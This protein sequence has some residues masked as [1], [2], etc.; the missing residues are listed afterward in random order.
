MKIDIQ[1]QG[2][3]C[4]FEKF[5]GYLGFRLESYDFKVSQAPEHKPP[6]L[7]TLNKSPS[8]AN[9]QV[10]ENKTP[11]YVYLGCLESCTCK[12]SEWKTGDTFFIAVTTHVVYNKPSK[13]LFYPVCGRFPEKCRPYTFFD[14]DDSISMTAKEMKHWISIMEQFIKEHLVQA[15]KI[16]PKSAKVPVN[17]TEPPT[18]TEK[19]RKPKK[20]NSLRSAIR[21]TVVEEGPSKEEQTVQEAPVDC[22]QGPSTGFQTDQRGKSTKHQG[23]AKTFKRKSKRPGRV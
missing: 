2:R 6:P 9:I 8:P 12:F 23:N 18:K 4:D 13:P 5:A 20:S 7:C 17:S 3:K 14:L 10:F 21:K 15:Q 1:F 16:Q 11:V 22:N 19:S